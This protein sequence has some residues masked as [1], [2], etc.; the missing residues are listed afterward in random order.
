MSP[1]GRAESTKVVVALEPLS[2]LRI[3]VSGRN[4]ASGELARSQLGRAA[5]SARHRHSTHLA[6]KVE[7]GDSRL[8]TYCSTCAY[9]T[10]TGTIDHY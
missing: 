8:P 6:I 5:T 4:L 1:L 7:V 3:D 10:A 9:H 2:W